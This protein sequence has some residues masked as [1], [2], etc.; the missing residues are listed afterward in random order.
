M[1]VEQLWMVNPFKYKESLAAAKEAVHAKGVRVLISQAP[2]HLYE[3]RLKGKKRKA[4]FQVTG[5]CGECRECLDYFGCPAMY[6]TGEEGGQ[7]AID[8]DICSGCAFC[9]QFCD[10]IRPVKAG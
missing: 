9:V 8:T 5:A 1:G 4:R 2:C 10:A 7:M 6:V 3:Q